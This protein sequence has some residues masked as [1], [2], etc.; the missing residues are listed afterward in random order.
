M[1]VEDE[2][3]KSLQHRPLDVLQWLQ[4]TVDSAEASTVPE[5]IEIVRHEVAKQL[6][7]LDEG[8]LAAV[9]L[10]IT[11]TFCAHRE[12]SEDPGQFE[13][14]LR[15]ALND[16]GSNRLWLE[17]LRLKTRAAVD[18]DELV[19]RDD[20]MGQLLAFAREIPANPD[21]AAEL[22]SSFSS[23]KLRMPQELLAGPDALVLEGPSFLSDLVTDVEND[24]LA[25]LF[26]QG[27]TI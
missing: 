2:Q 4:C 26:D 3:V 19:L 7:E 12:I 17:K 25:A 18:V 13:S 21:L 14:E 24:L 5:L 9:R 8:H 15:Q 20:P 11:G 10:T 27:A 6:N 23:L 16:F 1:E 22:T